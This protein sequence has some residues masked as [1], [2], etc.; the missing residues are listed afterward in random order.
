MQKFLNV[1]YEKFTE[2]LRSLNIVVEKRG[3][4]GILEGLF[5][6]CMHIISSTREKLKD[7]KK[8]NFDLAMEH[9]SLGNLND[10]ILRFKLVQKFAPNDYLQSSYYIG[11]C[12]ME[13]GNFEK[14]IS[15]LNQYQSTSHKSLQE[16]ALYCIKLMQSQHEAISKI[17]DSIV[18]HN[19][20]MLHAFYIKNPKSFSDGGHS[21]KFLYDNF[22]EYAEKN[23]IKISGNMLDL[24]CG[25]GVIGRSI[26]KDFQGIS[27]I[28]G[29]DLSSKMIEHCKKLKGDNK[30]IYN[31]LSRKSVMRYLEGNV[32]KVFDIIFANDITTY[33][34]NPQEILEKLYGIT[35]KKSIICIIFKIH[36]A[37][38]DII[39]DSIFEEF[40][41]SEAFVRQAIQSSQWKIT[42]EK[43]V[44]YNSSLKKMIDGKLFI[45]SK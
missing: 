23:S 3:V 18:A 21:I 30:K 2:F 20:D 14:A 45:L 27:Y 40:H 17:P 33:N 34:N 31:K 8:T 43:N 42:S 39:F 5:Q 7:I 10:A 36:D 29:I 12:Y 13:K 24:G 41:Y 26:I 6:Y 28:E 35:N 11:R 9:Y 44:K 32:N 37:E 16:E 38:Q 1:L 15:Y 25:I 22:R 4:S 19:F